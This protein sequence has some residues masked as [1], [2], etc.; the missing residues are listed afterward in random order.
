MTATTTASIAGCDND[1][2]Y[3]APDGL[4]FTTYCGENIAAAAYSTNTPTSRVNFTQCMNSCSEENY[5]CYGVVYQPSN[6]SCWELSNQTESTASNLITASN[7]ATALANQSQLT[8]ANTSCPYA[9]L[10]T[11]TTSGV[12]Y[13]VECQMGVTAGAYCP[14]SQTLCPMHVDTLDE[15][16][17]LCI[18]AHPLCLSASWNPGMIAGYQ[19]C[20]LQTA[21][22]PLKEYDLTTETYILHTAI[23]EFPDLT[24]GCPTDK[25]YTSQADN[26]N[27]SFKISCDQQATSATNLTFVHQP[28]ITACMDSCA[29]HTGSPACE[30]IVFD[31]TMGIGYQNCQLLNSVTMVQ[32]ASNVNYASLDSSNSSTPASSSSSSK[33]SGSS[34]KAWIAGPVI[35]GVVAIAAIGLGLWWWNRRKRSTTEPA[36]VP[37][38][39]K[40]N[41]Q[42]YDTTVQHTQSSQPAELPQKP[43]EQVP[44]HE[45]PGHDGAN[46]HE[47]PE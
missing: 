17:D 13:K 18:A 37:T 39:Y 2:N 6:N 30:A 10:S 15:C 31:P 41:P 14:W 19:N 11:Q 44:V 20:Y 4:N 25:Q 24:Q 29:T 16:A 9:N 26:T 23:M 8:L 34:S 35:G 45:L 28:N 22:Q 42:T 38:E 32:G 43:V 7:L 33:S 5:Y 40:N 3:T 27:A 1:G 12:N 36:N 46:V 47:L 21:S